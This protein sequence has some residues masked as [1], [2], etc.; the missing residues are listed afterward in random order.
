ME[1]DMNDPIADSQTEA[2][3][4]KLRRGEGTDTLR[5][6]VS[7]ALLSSMTK[8]IA[9]VAEIKSNL[10]NP[11]DLRRVI[12]ERHRALCAECPVRHPTN[13]SRKPDLISKVF[14]S[15]TMFFVIAVLSL[16]AAIYAT[17][18]K[19]GLDSVTD[20]ATPFVSHGK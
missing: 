13:D 19:Q 4:A 18:G 6:E 9:E 1:R 17:T 14:S 15:T 8:L 2:V 16:L 12:E 5:D 11:T 3:I 10:W 7:A 20:A